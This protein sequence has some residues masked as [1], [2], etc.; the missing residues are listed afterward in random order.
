MGSDDPT[1]TRRRVL[2]ASGAAVGAAVAAASGIGAASAVACRKLKYD[3]KSYRECPRPGESPD[4]P[5]IEAGTMAYSGC[6]N[7]DGQE[8]LYALGTGGAGYVPKGAT[9]PC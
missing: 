5:I 1:P 8:Y 9:E 6:T 4:G 2:K 3:Y 7:R